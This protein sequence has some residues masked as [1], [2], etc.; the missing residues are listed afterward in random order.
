MH[1]NCRPALSVLALLVA[2]ASPALAKQP[3]EKAVAN[4]DVGEG[5]E[6]T[7]F[8]S[9]PM[10]LS[11]SSIDIDHLGRVW[12]C[13]V[14]NYRGHRNKRQEGDRILVL[15]DTSGD[16][17][18]DKSTVFYQDARSIPSTGSASSGTR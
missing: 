15:E 6:T 3:P 16:G 10:M 14:V 12:V 1:I 13:E 18:A 5:L 4:L 2:L 8:A 17:K 11:P 7:L 9:E